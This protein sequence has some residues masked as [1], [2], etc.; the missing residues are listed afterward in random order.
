MDPRLEKYAAVLVNYSTRVQ[1][2]ERVLIKAGVLA[3]P[4]IK[5]VYKKVLD[6]GASCTVMPMLMFMDELYYAYADDEII[7]RRDILSKFVAEYYDVLI[8]IAADDNK[9][10]MTNVPPERLQWNEAA[11]RENS[12]IVM[13][14]SKPWM[15]AKAWDEPPKGTLRWVV[16]RYP[17]GPSA[18]DANMGFHEYQEFIL[19]AVG[20][21]EKDPFDFWMKVAM[22]QEKYVERLNKTT[23]IHM[24]G[25]YIDM[26]FNVQGRQWINCDGR[27]NMPD[28]EV[29]TSPW[30]TMTE[31]WARFTYPSVKSSVLVEDVYV[32]MEEGQCV[33]AEAKTKE[34][35]LFLNTLLDTD[36]YCRTLGELAVGLNPNVTRGTK[37]TL[38]DEKIVGTIHMA[39]GMGYPET[40]SANPDAGIHWDFICDMSEGSIY[41]DGEVIYKNGKFLF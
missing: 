22:S 13:K 26:R 4:L 38:F 36:Q 37:D 1:P 19:G 2:G 41:A 20:A 18:M 39:F 34:Q 8:S 5:A 33:K 25:P 23:Y 7:Q 16:C 29:F 32:E 40:G 3:E 31:G 30:E 12:K 17:T 27:F 9:R 14:R 28:G 24:E 21:N 35:T 10:S 15:E 11:T 6:A